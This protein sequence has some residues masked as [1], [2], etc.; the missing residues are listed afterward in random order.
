MIRWYLSGVAVVLTAGAGWAGDNANS[1]TVIQNGV[2]NIQ[3]TAQSGDNF[4]M[5][6]QN[7][8][9]NEAA[10]FQDGKNNFA[11][12]YQYGDAHEAATV[13]DGDNHFSSS[14]QVS[15]D[16]AD[17]SAEHHSGGHGMTIETLLEFVSDGP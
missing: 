4:S 1:S 3:A 10:T 12:T 16:D 9:G 13:Q 17:A 14:V 11:V 6:V 5:T 7:G 8:N 15:N 2:N